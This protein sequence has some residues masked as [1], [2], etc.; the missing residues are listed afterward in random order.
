MT[1][2]WQ[3]QTSGIV[4]ISKAQSSTALLLTHAAGMH[5][6]MQYMAV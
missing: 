1:L 2:A 3:G 4:V 5:E 6:T